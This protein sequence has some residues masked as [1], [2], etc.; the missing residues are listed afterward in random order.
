MKKRLISILTIAMLVFQQA[1]FAALDM[2]DEVKDYLCIGSQYTNKTY[3]NDPNGRL[4]S[5]GNF[6][7]YITYYYEDPVTDDPRNLYGMDLYIVGNS[8]EVNTDS[9]AEPGQVYVSED[10]EQWYALAGS[11]HYDDGA[12]W[13]YTIT[14]T[15]DADGMSSWTDNYENAQ[16]YAAPEWPDPAIYTQ[17]DVG[18]SESYSFCGVLLRSQDGTITGAGTADSYAG[19]ARF[20][21]VDHYDTNIRNGKLIETD[22]YIEAP[23]RA[24]GFDLE[25]AV[26]PD[27]MPVD[28]S[29]KEFHYIRVATASNIYAGGFKEKSTEVSVIARPAPQENEVGRTDMPRSITVSAGG[30][31][32]VVELSGD[33]RVYDIPASRSCTV[34]VDSEA[35]NVYINNRRALTASG[36]PKGIVR[37]ICQSGDKEPCIVY[38]RLTGEEPEPDGTE[39]PEATE[40]PEPT[41]TPEPTEE[42]D[43]P[44]GSS[45]GTRNISVSFTLYG[46]TRHGAKASHTYK[47]DKGSLPVWVRASNISVPAGST[48]YDVLRK[49]LTEEG[50]TWTASGTNYIS[51]INGLSEFDNGELSGWMYLYNGEHGETGIADQAVKSG[52]RIIF[53]YTDDYTAEQGSEKFTKRSSSAQREV[54]E[55]TGPD[56]KINAEAHERSVKLF[57]ILLRGM[58]GA[59]PQKLTDIV[60]RAINKNAGE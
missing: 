37:V 31:E 58:P 59:D 51:E 27:G 55:I 19:K 9:L 20:G 46:D 16:D 30:E 32:T 12:V 60:L 39:V 13:D 7:G 14:Y 17:N 33:T 25:W 26:D 21:Y 36:F 56:I 48:V 40:T 49:A 2:P 10:G 15:R 18:N 47:S 28:V 23:S 52:D 29:G 43:S 45:S 38:L 54:G 11:E 6:G 4:V 34:T 42:P 35:E 5:L 44:S 24:N 41:A 50:L 8:E 53:H 57:G 1:A 22:P 3:G